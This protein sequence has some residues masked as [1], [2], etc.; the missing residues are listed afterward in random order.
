MTLPALSRRTLLAG[1]L[2]AAALPALGPGCAWLGPKKPKVNVKFVIHDNDNSFAAS[3]YAQEVNT[4]ATTSFAYG[5]HT[6]Y[7]IIDTL[8]PGTYVFYA[9]LVEAPDDYHYGFTGYQAAAY[10]HMTRGGTRPEAVNLI[11]LDL[12]NGGSYKVYISDPWASMPPAGKPVTL[13]LNRE[14]QAA[15][16][17]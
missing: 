15:A 17:P 12:Q 1:L 5:P 2:T 10:G 4:G 14:I 16:K 13:P 6:P 3:V 11:A 7:I 8:K 9:R